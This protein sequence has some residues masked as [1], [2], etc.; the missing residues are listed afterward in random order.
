VMDTTAFKRTSGCIIPATFRLSLLVREVVVAATGGQSKCPETGPHVVNL[1]AGSGRGRLANVP[2]RS[3]A[4]LQFLHLR[5]L[6]RLLQ[7]GCRKF[8]VQLETHDGSL[9]PLLM[10]LSLKR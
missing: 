1:G 4:S 8:L 7:M 5:A 2:S 9:A 3:K 6:T 10:R